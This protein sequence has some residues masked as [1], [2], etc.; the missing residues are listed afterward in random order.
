MDYLKTHPEACARYTE[1][2]RKY[3]FSRREYYRQKD[4]F[5]REVLAV[6]SRENE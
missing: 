5:Y 6:A 4:R 2:K 1:I 3:A